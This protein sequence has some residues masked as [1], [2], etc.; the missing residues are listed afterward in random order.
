MEV[1]WVTVLAT[2]VNKDNEG[3]ASCSIADAE[4]PDVLIAMSS[5]ASMSQDSDPTPVRGGTHSL[6]PAAFTPFL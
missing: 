6:G 2:V 4:T 1:V 5:S 3:A